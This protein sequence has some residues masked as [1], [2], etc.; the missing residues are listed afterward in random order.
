MYPFFLTFPDWRRVPSRSGVLT[1][2]PR[3]CS[4]EHFCLSRRRPGFDSPTRSF[5]VRSITNAKT[6]PYDKTF[7]TNDSRVGPHR[8]TELAQWCLVSEIGRDRT[9]SPWCDRTMLVGTVRS[10]VNAPEGKAGGKNKSASTWART[11]DLSVNSRALC[12]LSHGGLII[13]IRWSRWGSNPR[14]WA[15]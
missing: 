14:P 2:N 3:W 7:D 6:P 10:M 12:Q 15:Y 13:K 5:L 9:F 4:W 8:S 11:R 1:S